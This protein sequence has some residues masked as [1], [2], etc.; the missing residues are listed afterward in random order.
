MKKD[1]PK[2]F[3]PKKG[4]IALLLSVKLSIH[5]KIIIRVDCYKVIQFITKQQFST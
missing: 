2:N 4:S 3:T 5:I 1:F